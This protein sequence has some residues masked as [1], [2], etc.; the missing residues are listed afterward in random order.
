MGA[1]V[2]VALKLTRCTCFHSYGCHSGY[3][4]EQRRFQI[5]TVAMAL[6]SLKPSYFAQIKANNNAHN[7]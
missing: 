5:L 2:A 3:L 7:R 1:T 4:R 6:I